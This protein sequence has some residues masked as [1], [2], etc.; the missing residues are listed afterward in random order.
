MKTRNSAGR[1]IAIRAPASDPGAV[2]ERLI[3]RGF[4][5][6]SQ[7]VQH[8][9]I[10]DKPDGSLFRDGSKLRIRLQDGMAQL[11]YKG[12]FIGDSTA[13]RRDEINVSIPSPQVPAAARLFAAL[14]FPLLFEIKK[15]RR[16]IHAR[17]FIDRFRPMA[18]TGSNY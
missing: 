9:M 7:F 18:H 8:D 3:D 16:N 13:S 15:E 14:G 1:E 17:G 10:F 6:G 12:Q 4:I 11:T 2:M 5:E